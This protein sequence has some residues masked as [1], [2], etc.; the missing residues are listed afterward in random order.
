MGSV[1]VWLIQYPS[2]VLSEHDPELANTTRK[3]KGINRRERGER[4]DDEELNR[5][6]SRERQHFGSG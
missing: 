1:S 4:R 5:R 2:V 6:E 3:G